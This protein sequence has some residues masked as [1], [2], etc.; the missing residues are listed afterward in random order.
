MYGLR[1]LNQARVESFL[2]I[3]AHFALNDPYYAPIMSSLT[4]RGRVRVRARAMG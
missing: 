2:F 1:K 3:L 4:S